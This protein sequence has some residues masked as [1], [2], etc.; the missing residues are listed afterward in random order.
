MS[1]YDA[2]QST[3]NSATCEDFFTSNF[4]TKS[5]AQTIKSNSKMH[6]WYYRIT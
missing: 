6:L 2:I 5:A 1:A 4:D 3:E